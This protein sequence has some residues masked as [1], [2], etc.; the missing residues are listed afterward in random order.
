VVA[1]VVVEEVGADPEDEADP[2][3]GA[4]RTS[5]LAR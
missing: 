5:T 2:A 3:H 1:L 4:Q